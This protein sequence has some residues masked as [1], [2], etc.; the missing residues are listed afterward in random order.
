MNES[1][2]SGLVLSVF[3]LFGD[4]QSAAAESGRSD[5][6]LKAYALSL[7]LI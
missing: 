4:V 1:V 3:L 6:P 7:P 5:G 2:S